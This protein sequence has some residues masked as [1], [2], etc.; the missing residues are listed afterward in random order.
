MVDGLEHSG[1]PRL[2]T[3]TTLSEIRGSLE[4]VAARGRR[5]DQQVEPVFAQ[6]LAQDVVHAGRQ[7]DRYARRLLHDPLEDAR[8]KGLRHGCGRAQAD[9]SAVARR[10][11]GQ[12]LHRIFHP[13][14]NCL[15]PAVE[16]DAGRCELHIPS[17]AGQ[18]RRAQHVL[19]TVDAFGHRRL[20]DAQALR[21]RA[22]PATVHDGH[23]VPEV[24]LVHSI[25]KSYGMLNFIY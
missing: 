21:G 11:V 5:T 19:E 12:F 6:S 8:Q 10:M 2:A 17:L 24:A 16:H 20:R 4:F 18:E 3:T 25:P 1:W 23:E 7:F 14:Q 22:Y 13:Q 9:M 15:R